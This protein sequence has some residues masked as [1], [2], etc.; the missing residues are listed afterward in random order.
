MVFESEQEIIFPP[1][2][3]INF[4]KNPMSLG[5]LEPFLLQM[6][7]EWCLNEAWRPKS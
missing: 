1:N 6:N 5:P 4:N 3:S 2:I 7:P